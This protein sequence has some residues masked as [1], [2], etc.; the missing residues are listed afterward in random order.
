MTTFFKSV[1]ICICVFTA[2]A[3]LFAQQ[4]VTSSEV[5]QVDPFDDEYHDDYDYTGLHPSWAGLAAGAG[6]AVGVFMPYLAATYTYSEDLT[7]FAILGGL[8]LQYASAVGGL[9]MLD[10]S[11]GKSFGLGAA[12]VAISIGGASAGMLVGSIFGATLYESGILTYRGNN[13]LGPVTISLFS[14]AA[15]GG[16][17]TAFFMNWLWAKNHAPV[18]VAE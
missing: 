8:G 3:Q 1:F 5:V 11:T 18:V 12:T 7:S 15:I 10:V 16:G 4:E 17:I 6:F 9:K 14:G 2:S 13:F